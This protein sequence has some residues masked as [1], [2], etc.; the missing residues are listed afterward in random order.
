MEALSK[1]VS[2][3]HYMTSI[4]LAHLDASQN[5][6]KAM[7]AS[8]QLCLDQ[9]PARDRERRFYTHSLECL[10]VASGSVVE[11]DKWTITP[12]EVEFGPKIGSGG[13]HVI[14]FMFTLTADLSAAERY[15]KVP[16]TK[17]LLL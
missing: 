3:T 6:I 17:L 10:S 11:L 9:R 4:G 8:L 13:L 1:S 12:F 5:N 7:M 14:L 2:L 16:G 15:S